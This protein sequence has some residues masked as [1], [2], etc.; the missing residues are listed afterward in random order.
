MRRAVLLPAVV[1]AAA[2]SQPEPAPH[3]PQVRAEPAPAA[4]AA[5]HADHHP[6]VNAAAPVQPG[7]NGSRRFGEPLAADA[8][9]V[10]LN[11][12]VQ[13]PQRFTGRSVRVEGTVAAVCQHMG[14]WMEIRDEA[15]QA[16]V[17]MHGHSFFVPRDV[18]GHRAAVQ[19]TVVAAHPPT[20]CDR[21]ARV[22]T[23]QVAQVELDATGVEVYD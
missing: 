4:A 12:I 1:L 18:N 16:H 6:A 21:E 2:C 8:Q 22:Q 14:C 9:R 11:E 23:G 19:A 13:T 7:A 10:R 15:M 5:P 20:E 3:T 17:R